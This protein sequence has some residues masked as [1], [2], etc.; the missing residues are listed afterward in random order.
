MSPSHKRWAKWP[1]LSCINLTSYGESR[2][3]KLSFI[4]SQKRYSQPIPLLML[5]KNIMLT[6]EVTYLPVAGFWIFWKNQNWLFN[7]IPTR[8][9]HVI[10][11]QGDKSYPCLFGIGFNN[12]ERCPWSFRILDC[13]GSI[14]YRNLQRSLI[15]QTVTGWYF[16]WKHSNAECLY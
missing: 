13:L 10:Y 5:L 2:R 16:F 14:W 12:S 8:L 4:G 6:T 9:C 1:K 15:L 3:P 7:P 11:C